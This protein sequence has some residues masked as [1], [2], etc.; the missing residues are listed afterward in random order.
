MNPII[1]TIDIPGDN[2]QKIMFRT[3]DIIGWNKDKYVA[4]FGFLKGSDHAKMY[5]CHSETFIWILCHNSNKILEKFE[6]FACNLPKSFKDVL[7][8][9]MRIVETPPLDILESCAKWL[10][11]RSEGIC[12]NNGCTEDEHKCESFAYIDIEENEYGDIV[13]FEF[14]DI[15]PPDYAQRVYNIALPLPFEGDG[16]KL[17][18]E[19]EQHRE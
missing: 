10:T 11:E 5:K 2:E 1:P 8:D 19:M 7:D 4:R 18:Q 12:K 6:G 13:G 9:P 15:C 3:G 14:Y 16:Q 17:L